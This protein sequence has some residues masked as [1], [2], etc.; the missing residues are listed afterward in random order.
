MLCTCSSSCSCG[1]I[2]KLKKERE[3]DYV[4]RFLHGLND[5]Y[6]PV[7][8]QVMLMEPMP[9]LVKTFSLVLQHEREFIGES[10][11]QSPT[12]TVVFSTVKDSDNSTFFNKSFS[13][14]NK[15]PGNFGKGSK[16]N[17]LCTYCG[18]TN[19]TVE[20]CFFKHGFLVGYE[21]H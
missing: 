19:H 10:S 13:N 2:P 6:A 14:H 16:G 7:Q 9:L 20:T 12:D 15:I 1:L 5:M 4:I 8:S 17:K 3:D 11:S 18:K 21:I